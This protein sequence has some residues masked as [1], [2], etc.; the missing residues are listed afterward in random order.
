MKKLLLVVILFIA[1]ISCKKTSND[2]PLPNGTW[3]E[4]SQGKDT[5]TFDKFGADLMLILKREGMISNGVLIPNSHVGPYIYTLQKDTISMRP[6]VSNSLFINHFY[7]NIDVETN[8]LSIG[9]FYDDS[10]TRG[11]ILTFTKKP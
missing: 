7:F 5:I 3:I 6:L 10:K 4:A 8:L 11:E 9:N 2:T 1:F